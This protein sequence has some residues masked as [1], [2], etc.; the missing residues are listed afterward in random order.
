MDVRVKKGVKAI[1]ASATPKTIP[2]RL[3]PRCTSRVSRAAKLEQVGWGLASVFL[4]LAV[5]VHRPRNES[6][7]AG[8]GAG[9]WFGAILGWVGQSRK[10]S[11]V[12]VQ[13][14]RASKD[15]WS[16]RFR[17]KTFADVFSATNQALVNKP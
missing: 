7:W 2:V 5:F 8:A 12:G 13:A 9:F 11:L 17:D 16:F 6:E 15:K 3:C 4:F 10:R 1:F 14:T